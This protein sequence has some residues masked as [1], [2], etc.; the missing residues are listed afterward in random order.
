MEK[1]LKIIKAILLAIDEGHRDKKKII[2]TARQYVVVKCDLE[3]IEVVFDKSF[4]WFF[5]DK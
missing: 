2:S 3:D 1:E 5:I 4:S